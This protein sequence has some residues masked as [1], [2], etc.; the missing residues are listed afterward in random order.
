VGVRNQAA[1]LV[2]NLDWT[3]EK[4]AAWH[5]FKFFRREVVNKVFFFEKKKQK[6]FSNSALAAVK[7]CFK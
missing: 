2:R 1:W 7:Y 6:T 4:P 5:D 3:G